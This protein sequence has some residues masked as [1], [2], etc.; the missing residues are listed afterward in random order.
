MGD[1]SNVNPSDGAGIL[2]HGGL[3]L[4]ASSIVSNNA[5]TLCSNYKGGGISNNPGATL[6]VT[7][8]TDC[9]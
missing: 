1:S 8:S 4:N 5:F 6:T 7:G 2:N 3:T 9:G